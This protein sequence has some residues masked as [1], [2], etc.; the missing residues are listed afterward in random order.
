MVK[1]LLGCILLVL[2]RPLA[3]LA[4]F[5]LPARALGAKGGWRAR[6]KPVL[7]ASEDAPRE[8]GVRFAL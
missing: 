6:F 4:L 7:G 8:N 3:L 1:F 2:C 5:D